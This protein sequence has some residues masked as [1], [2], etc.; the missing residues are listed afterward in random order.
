MLSMTSSAPHISELPAPEQPFVHPFTAA[1]RQ[2]DP[3]DRATTHDTAPLE[4]PPHSEP[5]VDS[6]ALLDTRSRRA[7]VPEGTA[8]DGQYLAFEDGSETWLIPISDKLLHIGRGFESDLRLEHRHV[9]RSHAIVVRYG[10]H[11]RVLDDR[12]A[13]GTYVNGRRVIAATLAEGDVVR[14]GPVAFRYLTVGLKP[15]RD[16]PRRPAP[17]RTRTSTREPA[18]AG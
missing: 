4:A 17:P 7:A 3:A 1:L 15:Y 18:L 2:L 5:I 11:A 12:S 16:E 6:Y 14:L 10:R 13:N 9:S 8:P